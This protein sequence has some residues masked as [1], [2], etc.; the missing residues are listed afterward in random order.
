MPSESI[1]AVV[2]DTVHH[3]D[4]NGKL[5]THGA[6]AAQLDLWARHF[7]VVLFCGVLLAGSPPAGFAPYRSQHIQMV[8]LAQAGGRGLKAKI[9][10][11]R[12]WGSWLR[13][14]AP[15]LRSA[16]A[17]HLRTP[18][19]VTIPGIIAS[20]VLVRHRYA[21]YAGSWRPYRNE[22]LTYRLQRTLLRRCFGGTVHAYLPPGE[23]PDRPNVRPSFSPVLS[24]AQLDEVAAAA[25]AAR[26]ASPP[27]GSGRCLR[28]VC[29][30][31]F[32]VNK[33]QMVL[34]EALRELQRGGIAVEC[35]FIGEGT[36]YEA[37]KHAAKALNAVAF[38]SR[39]DRNQIFEAMAWADL[40]VLP[41]F[42]EGYPK[43]LLEGMAAGALPVASDT[44]VNRATAE[45]RGWVFDPRNPTDL[46]R[47]LRAALAVPDA[48]WKARR[49]AAATYSRSH[50]LDEFGTEVDH[51]VQTVWGIDSGPRSRD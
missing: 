15:V 28:V 36:E 14:M 37:V 13:T 26:A 39:A 46:A 48:E 7:D 20:R 43:V 4:E 19:N 16:D 27:L 51:I 41:T 40:N 25:S 34:V 32:S 23:V 29:V 42:H 47:V 22:P 50:T 45:G 12:S 38:S 44:P 2:G 5:H 6:L 21:M 30:G 1:L 9:R 49:D 18:C 11:L 35:R 17:V 33:N 31:R 10:V 3:V 8:P 24:S